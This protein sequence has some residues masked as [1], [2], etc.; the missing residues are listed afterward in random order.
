MLFGTLLFS[1]KPCG[2]FFQKKN[3]KKESKHRM[4]GG[5]RSAISPEGWAAKQTIMRTKRSGTTLA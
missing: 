1:A 5:K 4:L 2:C 3:R